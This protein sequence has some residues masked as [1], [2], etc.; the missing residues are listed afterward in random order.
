MLT[1]R[2]EADVLNAVVRWADAH[3]LVRAVLLESSRAVEQAPLDALSDYDILIVV[4]DVDPFADDAWLS[5]FGTPLVVFRSSVRVAETETSTCLVL[6][7]DYV[8]IDVIIWPVA[9]LGQ[10]VERGALPDAL[11]WGYRVL[12]DKDHL[13]DRLPAPTRTAHIPARPSAAAY[14]AL[15]NEFWWESTYVA[16]NLWRDELAPAKYSLEVV[17]TFDLLRRML[18]WRIEVDAEWS[19]KPGVLG[20]GL[21]RRLAPERWTAFEQ[22]LAG[23]SIEDNWQALFA[24][25]TLFAQV[26]REVATALGFTYPNELERKVSA[27]LHA[28]RAEPR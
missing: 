10:V 23:A 27:Y 17:M 13:T 5:A 22:T 18:E 25:T 12:L 7:D 26:A 16:K 4:A 11:D 24:T 8:K 1:A 15:V 9:L 14:Q 28:V 19:W 3:A 2:S 20:R 6:Y 21:K